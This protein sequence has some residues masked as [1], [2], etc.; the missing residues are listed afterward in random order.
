MGDKEIKD[1]VRG[2]IVDII[3]GLIGDG[4]FEREGG[5]YSGHQIAEEKAEELLAIKEL[6]IVDRDAKL[7]DMFGAKADKSWVK[8]IK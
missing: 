6:A 5:F 4:E 2:E 1:R 7:S 3:V 8:E